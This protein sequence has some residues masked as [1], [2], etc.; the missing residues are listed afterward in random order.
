MKWQA[1][2]T[3]EKLTSAAALGVTVLAVLSFS[4]HPGAYTRLGLAVGSAMV[5]ISALFG[6][7]R[8]IFDE[9]HSRFSRLSMYAFIFGGLLF[10]VAFVTDWVRGF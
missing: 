3:A 10:C 9:Q 6:G 4:L 7:V 1:I 2:T 8:P 5:G